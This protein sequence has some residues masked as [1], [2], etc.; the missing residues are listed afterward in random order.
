MIVQLL[1]IPFAIFFGDKVINGLNNSVV[2]KCRGMS[3]VKS[4]GYSGKH[5]PTDD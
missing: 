3:V 5:V 1:N 2:V 4:H